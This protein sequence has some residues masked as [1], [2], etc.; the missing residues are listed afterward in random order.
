MEA[1][2]STS[3]GADLVDAI[4]K[5][6]VQ[7]YQGEDNVRSV[8]DAVEYV[9]KIVG[10]EHGV[11]DAEIVMSPYE[12]CVTS[13][14]KRVSFTK[15]VRELKKSTRSVAETPEGVVSAGS[16]AETPEEVVSAGSI[17]ETPE[18]VASTRSVVETPEGGCVGRKH[19]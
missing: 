14:Q 19:R 1:Q 9:R 5:R 18:G 2:G 13:K 12:N 8:E 7:H 17:V 11:F 10:H 4:Q 15:T 6:G 16:V 3:L